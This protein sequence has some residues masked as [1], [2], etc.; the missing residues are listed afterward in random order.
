MIFFSSAQ[1]CL[2]PDFEDLNAG[3]TYTEAEQ[4]SF[5]CLFWCSQVSQGRFGPVYSSCFFPRRS[6]NRSICSKKFSCS[7]SLQFF[8]LHLSFFF[9]SLSISRHELWCGK[10]WP[11]PVDLSVIYHLPSASASAPSISY[12]VIIALSHLYA[13][14]HH[15]IIQNYTLR[16]TF[17]L[18][19][20][21]CG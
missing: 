19:L 13:P 21:I 20:F 9:F 14:Q 18:L 16:F 7:T 11:V 6:R 12:F 8:N 15:S 10:S 1:G 5:R 2:T 3:D 17:Q 4:E